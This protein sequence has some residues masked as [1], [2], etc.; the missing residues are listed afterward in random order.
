[1]SIVPLRTPRQVLEQLR[2][3]CEHGYLPD[4]T[5]LRSY[6]DAFEDILNGLDWAAYELHLT[7]GQL[8]ANGEAVAKGTP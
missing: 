1:M 8:I 5:A 6:I 4:R 7:P 2:V 3:A